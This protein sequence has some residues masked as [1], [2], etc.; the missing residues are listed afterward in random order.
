MNELP[1][2]TLKKILTR[3]GQELAENPRRCEAFLKDFCPEYKR[4]VFLLMCVVNESIPAKLLKSSGCLSR[5]KLVEY[6]AERLHR[7]CG[8]TWESARWAVESWALALGIAGGVPQTTGETYGLAGPD[9]LMAPHLRVVTTQKEALKVPPGAA[10]AKAKNY[11]ADLEPETVDAC[12]GLRKPVEVVAYVSGAMCLVGLAFPILLAFTAPTAVVFTAWALIMQCRVRNEI[13]RRRASQQALAASE[14]ALR[15]ASRRLSRLTAARKRLDADRD[16]ALMTLGDEIDTYCDRPAIAREKRKR[17]VVH[18]KEREYDQRISQL[19]EAISSYAAEVDR[20]ER[21]VAE[22]AR[23]SSQLKSQKGNL[24][25]LVM[26]G[27]WLPALVGLL[28]W[29]LTP[30]R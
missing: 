14:E 19:A 8:L 4:E 5:E 24:Y 3:Y 26:L 27:F 23:A 28:L 6:Y 7:N 1:R 29:A 2:Q 30:P 17:Y 10:N 16:T 13:Q 18:E 25:I 21:E 22:V 11:I 12:E 20:L 15:K 9:P